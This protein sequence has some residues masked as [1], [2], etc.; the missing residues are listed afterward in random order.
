IPCG[1]EYDKVWLVNLIQSHCGVSFSPVDFHYINSRAFFFVQDASVASKI[2]DVRNQIYDERRHRIAIFVQPS[3]VPYSVQNKFTPEQ[4]EHLKANM[5]K[6]Y[7]VSQQALNL[8]QLRYDP[9]M[10]DPQ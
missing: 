5:C 2:K 6:R 8:Q 9:G 10:A 4:M 3:I 7:D 1:R